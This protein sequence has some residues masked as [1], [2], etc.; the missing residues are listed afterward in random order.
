[1]RRSMKS[2]NPHIDVLRVKRLIVTADDFGLSVPVNEAVERAHC[3]GVLSAASL[4]IGAPA[5]E[6]AVERARKLPSLGVGL[7]LTLLDGRPVLPPDQ[8]PGLLDA[9]GRFFSDP[10]RLG[11]LLY[12]SRD[13]QRQVSAEIT[14]QFERF[15]GTGLTLDH[16]NAHKHFH[17][18]PVLLRSIADIAP[19]VGRPPVRTPLEPFIPSFR[20]GRNRAFGRLLSSLF[21]FAH[22]RRMRRRLR[23]AGIPSNDHL[24]GLNDSGALIEPLLLGLLD[25]LPDGIS[26]IYCHPATRS[27]KGSDN[28]PS[29][30]RPGSELAALLSPAVKEAMERRGLRPLSYRAALN[31]VT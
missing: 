25:H 7:H 2:S 3:E 16:V 13:L 5:V 8:I 30:Y 4:M 24:F 31:S 10:V 19:R 20:A 14:A 26:E 21:Y 1:L 23:E 9:D 15:V 28:L 6:D 27:W 18:H 17:L 12:F 11:I 22:T 29:G